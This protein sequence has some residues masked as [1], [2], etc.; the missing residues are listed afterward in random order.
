MAPDL[1]VNPSE[2]PDMYSRP[3]EAM[4]NVPA[5]TISGPVNVFAPLRVKV[6]APLFT[7]PPEPLSTGARV[8]DTPIAVVMVGVAPVS[9]NAVPA[10][11]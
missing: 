6:P 11:W 10:T 4:A 9:A 5:F 7:S 3:P 8:A 2:P 1:I